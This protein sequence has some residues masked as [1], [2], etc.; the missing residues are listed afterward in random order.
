MR[1]TGANVLDVMEGLRGA[2]AE[3]SDGVLRRNGLQLKQVYDETDYIYSAV[4]LVRNNIVLGGLLTI[5]VLL[6]FLKSARSTLVVALA[7]PTSVVGT[8]LL[9]NLMGRSLNVISL[10]GLA[11]AVGMLVDNAVVV[12][13]NIYPPLPGGRQPRRGGRSRAR[14]RSGVPSSRVR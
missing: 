6:I 10:A 12:L 13:E 4:G 7:I 5:A 2:V 14:R 3:L 8:F 11:F 1:E 9:L